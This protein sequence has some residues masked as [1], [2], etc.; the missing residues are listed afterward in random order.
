LA[1]AGKAP[2]GRKA[3]AD[4]FPVEVMGPEEDPVSSTGQ[5][6][7]DLDRIRLVVEDPGSD[8]EREALR[9]APEVLHEVP[10]QE[11]APLEVVQLLDDQTLEIGP[12]I[13][14]DGDDRS[15]PGL[16]EHV[17]MGRLRRA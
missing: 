8:A 13:G 1:A 7:Q 14:L 5:E 2:C 6:L 3:A 15:G 10:A 12:G 9:S 4:Y 17:R 16:F 11:A